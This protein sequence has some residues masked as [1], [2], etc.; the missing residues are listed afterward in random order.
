M[1]IRLD[2]IAPF[3][4]KRSADARRYAR[5]M[6]AGIEFPPVQVIK[7]TANSYRLFDGYHRTRAA[8][9]LGQSSIKAH[10]IADETCA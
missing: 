10:V 1:M 3:R 7:T 4:C 5:M 8:K 6:Q 2:Q 9:L